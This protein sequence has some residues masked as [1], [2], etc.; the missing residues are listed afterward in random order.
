MLGKRVA[1]LV[2]QGG[3]DDTQVKVWS[4]SSLRAWLQVCATAMWE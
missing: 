3:V 4:M 2:R 1:E